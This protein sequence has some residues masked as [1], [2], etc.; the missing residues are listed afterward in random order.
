MTPAERL[1][2][3]LNIDP[4]EL[5]DDQSKWLVVELRSRGIDITGP[6]FRGDEYLPEEIW[7]WIV[8]RL[9]FD[10]DE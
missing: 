1:S 7:R 6:D 2:D 3:L 8:T 4:D 10:P 5:S 9:G